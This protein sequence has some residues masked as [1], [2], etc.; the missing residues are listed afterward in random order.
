M[1][2][3]TLAVSMKHGHISKKEGR[4]TSRNA[5]HEAVIRTNSDGPSSPVHTE[6]ARKSRH[7]LEVEE[8]PVIE[9]EIVIHHLADNRQPQQRKETQ[10][11]L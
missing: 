1:S 5:A 3:A 4:Y 6:P 7:T 9:F 8:H 11:R 10:P 2:T